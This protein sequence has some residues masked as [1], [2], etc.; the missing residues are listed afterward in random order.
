MPRRRNLER[1]LAVI[2]DYILEDS[3]GKSMFSLDEIND[4]HKIAESTLYRI[5]D[6]HNVPRRKVVKLGI[7]HEIELSVIED[8]RLKDSEGKY[9][10]SPNEIAYNH[11]IVVKTLYRILVRHSVPRR[12]P[13]KP[14]RRNTGNNSVKDLESRIH[15]IVEAYN[16][17][18]EN[19]KRVYKLRKLYL[20]FGCYQITFYT[21]LKIAGE[22]YNLRVNFRRGLSN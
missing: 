17:V 21:L 8:Y 22:K 5:L 2:T 16:L 4:N 20:K 14:R 7:D 3:E 11:K 9:V 1:E 12:I 15:E 18:D 19:G 13:M 10:F 6:R